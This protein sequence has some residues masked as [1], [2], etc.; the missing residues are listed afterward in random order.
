[1]LTAL[2]VKRSTLLLFPALH[3]HNVPRRT[4]KRFLNS[5]QHFCLPICGPALVLVDVSSDTRK[6]QP[7]QEPK[8]LIRF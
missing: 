6:V 2:D 8:I 3:T 5:Q 4:S 1:M 7:V